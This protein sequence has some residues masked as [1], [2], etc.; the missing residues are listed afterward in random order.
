MKFLAL[1][2]QGVEVE[3]YAL[4][5]P[6]E[7]EQRHENL[8][9]I[10]API[11]YLPS[12]LTQEHWHIFLGNTAH[13]PREINL[14]RFLGKTNN[15]F[16]KGEF[17]GKRD[18]S[19]MHRSLQALTLAMLASSRGIDHFHAHFATD[20]TTVAQLASRLSGISYSFT[21]HAKDIYHTYVS[22]EADKAMLQS[23]IREA[24]FVVTVSE[25][26][27]NHLDNLKGDRSD[28]VYRLYNGIDLSRFYPVTETTHSHRIL[29]V[30]RLVEKKRV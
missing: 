27:R 16:L 30:G 8:T 25:Y 26:N 18:S 29:A 11:F 4:M 19:A 22:I 12:K 9:L 21:A 10:K 7:D 20:A 28:N 17:V 15:T 23:K 13:E 2:K 1:E 5:L 14:K 6:P 24:S 3:I